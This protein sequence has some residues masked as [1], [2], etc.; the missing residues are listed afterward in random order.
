MSI[1][2]QEFS[3]TISYALLVLNSVRIFKETFAAIKPLKDNLDASG[4]RNLF[5]QTK[6]YGVTFPVSQILSQ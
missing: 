2:E 4:R 5:F 1:P 3:F 6:E